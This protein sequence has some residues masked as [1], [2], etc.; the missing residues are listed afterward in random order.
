MQLI[1]CD[2]LPF[3]MGDVRPIQSEAVFGVTGYLPYYYYPSIWSTHAARLRN[4]MCLPMWG[5]AFSLLNNCA[6]DA[7]T[8]RD[9]HDLL[10]TVSGLNL[11]SY[12]K[13]KLAFHNF[14]ILPRNF[15]TELL[16]H[17]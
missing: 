6:S 15:P 8:M 5:F 3:N 7:E 14:I 9:F 1:H 4:P 10:L 16:L 11:E 17:V 2:D 12:M 13:N